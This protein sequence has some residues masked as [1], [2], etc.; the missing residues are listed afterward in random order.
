MS[1]NEIF[2]LVA[3]IFATALLTP[4]NDTVSGVERYISKY[5]SFVRNLWWEVAIAEDSSE[6]AT[7]RMTLVKMVN[8][9]WQHLDRV[10]QLQQRGVGHVL[11]PEFVSRY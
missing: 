4:K 11:S 9:A 2:L 1:T 5:E 3:D 7:L 10:F 6:Q 8:E